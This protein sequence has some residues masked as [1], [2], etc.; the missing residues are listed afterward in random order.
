MMDPEQPASETV[1]TEFPSHWLAQFARNNPRRMAALSALP[2]DTELM[3]AS[4]VGATPACGWR[5]N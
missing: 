2:G 5:L 4:S 1:P 3:S